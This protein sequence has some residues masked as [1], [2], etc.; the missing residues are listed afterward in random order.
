MTIETIDEDYLKEIKKL[1]E[2]KGWISYLDNDIKLSN[3]IKNNQILRLISRA[4]LLGFI[5]YLTDFEHILY[6]QD[7]TIA[8]NYRRNG[9]D[10][11]LIENS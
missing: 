4:Q 1:Y 10:Q 7:L 8:K 9:G 11:I 2:E 5:R 3:A 6:I